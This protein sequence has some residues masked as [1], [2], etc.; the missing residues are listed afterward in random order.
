MPAREFVRITAI[1]D[2]VASARAQLLHKLAMDQTGQR[3]ARNELEIAKA[4]P[5][6]GRQTGQGTTATTKHVLV[7]FREGAGLECCSSRVFLA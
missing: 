5:D 1:D 3:V 4:G 2:L 7:E 6:A